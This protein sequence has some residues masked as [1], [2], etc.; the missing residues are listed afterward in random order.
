MSNIK[1][2]FAA[3]PEFIR[4]L[5]N[6][7][8]LA[9]IPETDWVIASGMTSVSHSQG[10]LYLV[11]IV[12][13]SFEECYPAVEV[14]H[15]LDRASYGDEQE[16]NPTQFSAHGVGLRAGPDGVHTLYVVNHGGREAVEVFRVN[17]NGSKPALTWVGA[18]AAPEWAWLN[19]VAPHPGGGFVVS[20]TSTGGAAGFEKI[21]AAEVSGNVLRWTDVNTPFSV[22]DGSEGSAPNGVAVSADGDWCFVNWWATKEIVKLPLTGARGASAVHKVS[23]NFHPD[24]LTWSQDG[25]HLLTTGQIGDLMQMLGSFNAEDRCGYP[26][27]IVRVDPE[28]MEAVVLLKYDAPQEFGAAATALEV[29]NDIWVGSARNDAVA[30]FTERL[31][32]P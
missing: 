9:R 21:F 11:N 28:T 12:D 29:G 26:F 15:E 10:H 3:E 13:H 32:K 8:D 7:E 17:A 20:N 4:G 30:I 6:P 14:R 24:N 1:P 2:S 27:E 18:V 22:I 19:D 25:S 5:I 23:V 31:T 16:P